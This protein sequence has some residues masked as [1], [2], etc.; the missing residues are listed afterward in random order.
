MRLHRSLRGLLVV[1]GL[2][3][4]VV[5]IAGGTPGPPVGAQTTPTVRQIRVQGRGEVTATPDIALLAVSSTVL[6]AEPG[7]AFERV[8]ERVAAVYAVL[9]EAGVAERDIRTQQISLFQEYRYLPP[10]GPN[11]PAPPPEFLGWRARQSLSIKLRDFGRVGQTISSTVRALGDTAEGLNIGFAID[12]PDA[13]TDR[14]RGL[15]ADDARAKAELLAERLGAR[16]GRLIYAQEGF[17]GFN[18]S[19]P[20]PAPPPTFA[21]PVATAR[22][23]IAVPVSPG[24]QTVVV[25][26]EAVYEV[27]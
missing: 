1:F 22:P 10:P 3:A 16:L 15:A 7:E 13:L 4:G 6:R 11:E 5:L 21:T 20:P 18:V 9:R 23:P 24:E 12:D 8:T 26:I 19:P 17:G 2:L 25:V 14:A 27:E